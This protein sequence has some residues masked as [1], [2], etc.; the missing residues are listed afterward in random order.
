M[1][2]GSLSV[3][4]MVLVQGEVSTGVPSFLRIEETGNTCHGVGSPA[5]GVLGAS[6]KEKDH[7]QV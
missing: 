2:P 3:V 7:T 6:L 5:L 4:L 1:R